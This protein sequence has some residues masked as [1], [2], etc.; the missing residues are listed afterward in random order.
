MI[1]DPRSMLENVKSA[2]PNYVTAPEQVQQ[3]QLSWLSL[4]A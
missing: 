1:P 3:L 2:S 4:S